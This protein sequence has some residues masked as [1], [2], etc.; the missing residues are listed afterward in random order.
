MSLHTTYE[1]KEGGHRLTFEP[2]IPLGSSNF[3]GGWLWCTGCVKIVPARIDSTRSGYVCIECNGTQFAG[4]NVFECPKCS[5]ELVPEQS[6]EENH[7]CFISRTEREGWAKL[8]TLLIQDEKKRLHETLERID[9]VQEKIRTGQT[10]IVID[11]N[12]LFFTYELELP[13]KY[14]IPL[15]AIQIF[16][17][18]GLI[19]SLVILFI[20]WKIAILLFCSA[21]LT[22]YCMKNI[23]Y[24]YI[25]V[26]CRTNKNFLRAMLNS[27][28]M[29]IPEETSIA[30][31]H[32]Y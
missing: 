24:Y 31:S 12:L 5:G 4:L 9:D 13:R 17:F 18:L 29:E 11:Y 2:Y 19:L 30:P 27:G 25:Y 22:I 16:P 14:L 28:V 23:S 32:L 8:R 6:D 1:C 21:A 15:K 3:R 7:V 20:N 10:K 26:R